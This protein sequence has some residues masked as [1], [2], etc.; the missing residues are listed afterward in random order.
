[1]REIG[2]GGMGVVYE[3][4]DPA[5]NR[6]V[7]IKVLSPGG[8]GPGGDT[9]RFRRE[10]EAAAQVNHPNCVQIYDI[11]EEGGQPFLVMEL[12]PGANA[13]ALVAKAGRL[14]WADATRIIVAACKGLTAIHD[15]GLIH[16]DVKPSNLLISETGA[17]KL[18]D[19]GLARIVGEAT[20]S[21]TGE[22]TLGTPHYMSPE[23]CMNESVDPR[24]DVYALGATYFT[25]LVGRPPFQAERDLQ[26]MF[27]HCNNPVPDACA[28]VP[29]LPAICGEVIRKAMAKPPIDRYQSAA[30]LQ[31]ALETSLA[32][33]APTESI[34]DAST[35][36]LPPL[37]LPSTKRDL[38]PQ[39]ASTRATGT[40]AASRTLKPGVTRRHLLWTI[41]P[42]VAALGVGGYFLF[43]NRDTNSASGDP[44]QPPDNGGDPP[45]PKDPP[46][47]KV[48]PIEDST[49]W[50]VGEPVHSVA[51]SDDNRWVAAGCAGVDDA[52]SLK[53]F[54][55]TKDTTKP[56]WSKA[57]TGRGHGV[58]FSPDGTLLALAT[59]GEGRVI[60][61]S[62]GE[63]H[64]LDWPR[65][66]TKCPVGAVAFSPDGKMLAAA[67]NRPFVPLK[68]DYPST[69]IPA[70]RL[71]SVDRAAA[72]FLHDMP[73]ATADIRQLSFS[74][75]SHWLAASVS[76]Y[77]G[78]LGRIDRAVFLCD[79]GNL[80]NTS[81]N[82]I[83]TPG[84][85][86]GP[87]AV[88]ARNAW[89][90][91]VARRDL[92]D[93]FQNSQ[94]DKQLPLWNTRVEPFA[95][96]LA[97]DGKL[98]AAAMREGIEFYEPETGKKRGEKLE[99]HTAPI[100]TLTFTAD[101]RHVISSGSHDNTIRF[102]KVP[103]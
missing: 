85:K 65:L 37:S 19:F 79:V 4:R 100:L 75:D 92:V 55:R 2:R 27:A 16:R 33:H 52:G 80:Q 29:E 6:P 7:A 34:A 82:L 87:S 46:Q 61:L 25:L 71:W 93:F 69:D 70:I 43:R 13:G 5:L 97:P 48:P 44:K 17:V 50:N 21:L 35:T 103:G 8:S 102:W 98:L 99:G 74:P 84:I 57:N 1:M 12:V 88:F 54:D 3:A 73:M 89:L 9:R 20:L 38:E 26:V 41:P 47:Q 94:L 39:S 18:A 24:T 49:V 59:H 90:L 76:S 86:I 42:A 68:K 14:A 45:K 53:L 72:K 63:N 40:T 11:G 101:G 81:H 22:R 58:A 10:A 32:M 95:I 51:I 60:V 30:D 64:E 23:Q 78:G 56:V 96:A 62:T 67:L 91:A 36:D 83:G 15:R 66:E 31:A 28:L 77:G